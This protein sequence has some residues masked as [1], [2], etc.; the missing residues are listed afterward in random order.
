MPPISRDQAPA[1]STTMSA[2][3]RPRSVTI[4]VARPALQ[5]ISRTAQFSMIST[6]ARRAA[7]RPL[8]A[9]FDRDARGDL[10]L[11]GKVRPQALAF[12][13]QRQERLLAGFGLDR[14]R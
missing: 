13:R 6:P 10:Q 1:A 12:Q 2:G 4:P 7:D 3:S 8:V 5:V 14:S 9:I 11:A